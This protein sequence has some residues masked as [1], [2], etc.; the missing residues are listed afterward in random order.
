LGSG[1]RRICNCS[2]QM[3]PIVTM[4]VMSDQREAFSAM[5][6]I[7]SAPQSRPWFA[8]R[9]GIAHC[10]CQQDRRYRL[11]LCVPKIR[12]CNMVMKAAEDGRRYDA[13]HVLDRAI[14]RSVLVE[15][16]MSP[17]LIIISGILHN[18]RHTSSVSG[19]SALRPKQS[20]GRRTRVGSIRSV[21]RQSR[22]AKASPWR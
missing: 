21:F 7:S 5:R 6:R 8:R 18:K 15:R 2:H 9:G 10:A 12:F 16:P 19:A 14:D 11:R 1:R 22:S 17:Q 20:Y 3:L 13:A 4:S